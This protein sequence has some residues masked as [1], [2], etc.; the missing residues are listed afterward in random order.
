MTAQD[1]DEAVYLAIG[2]TFII[3]YL[4]AIVTLLTQ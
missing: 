1:R 3:G 4:G 2:F